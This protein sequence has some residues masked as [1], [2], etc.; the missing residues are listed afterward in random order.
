M[1]PFCSLRGPIVSLKRPTK[2][3]RDTLHPYR[4]A[5]NVWESNPE[6]SFEI[7]LSMVE[8]R[9][10]HS[11][12]DSSDGS[13][14]MDESTNSDDDKFLCESD[15]KFRGSFR[16]DSELTGS[17]HE[18][19]KKQIKNVKLGLGTSSTPGNLS[20]KREEPDTSWEK[21]DFNKFRRVPRAFWPY[22][23]YRMYDSYC[24]A[25]RAAGNFC[26]SPYP[27]PSFH[28]CLVFWTSNNN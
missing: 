14:R 21:M 9:S 22:W 13:D 17:L 23:V 19:R 6:E 1:P 24:L 28:Q 20:S 8:R 26:S 18:D 3:S 12:V 11:A 15:L 7:A 27:L 16:N 10:H 5:D 25:E 4:D 2:L